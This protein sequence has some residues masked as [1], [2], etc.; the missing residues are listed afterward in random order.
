MVEQS[1]RSTTASVAERKSTLESLVTTIDLRT[2]DLDQRLSRFTGLLDESLAAAEERAR[3]IARVVAETAGA[4]SAAISR[5]FE[6]VRAA[7]EEERRLTA[8]AMSEIY[9]QSTQEADAMFKQSADKFATMVASMKQMAAE[10]QHELEATRNELR[11]GVLEM[12]Q[13]AAESTAQMRKVIVDQ[14]EALAELNRIVAHHGRGLDVVTTG[15]ASV[16]REEEPMLATAGGRG[17]SR[18]A[19]AAHARR[20]QRLDPAAA[21]SRPAGLAPHRSAAGFAGEFRPGPRR[22][23]FRSVEPHRWRRRRQPRCRRAAVR[24]SRPPAAIR[25]SRCRSTSAA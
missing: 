7:A 2:T 13:E 22:M 8:D 4:G 10:M 21:G 23:A 19:R 14:I 24:R 5:Q 6:A 12:P 3:D 20:R 1:N 17:E 9:Q 15:R 11:R 16:Q 25:W 18:A